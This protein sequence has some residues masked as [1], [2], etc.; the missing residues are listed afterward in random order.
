MKI[1]S[2]HKDSNGKLL[3]YTI[4]NGTKTSRDRCYFFCTFLGLSPQL[5]HSEYIKEKMFNGG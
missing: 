3:G 4:E 5:K 1:V 2:R